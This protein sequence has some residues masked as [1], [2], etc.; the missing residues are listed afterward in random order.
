M[1]F[2]KN[3]QDFILVGIQNDFL[4]ENPSINKESFFNG[5]E[6]NKEAFL[7]SKN[8][9]LNPTL[10]NAISDLLQSNGVVE[11]ETP[12]F[13]EGV[14]GEPISNYQ[15]FVRKYK[16]KNAKVDSHRFAKHTETIRV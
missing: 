2:L 3:E 4:N 5:I 6:N 14:Y 11:S 12:K 9:T 16:R 1:V 8:L 10:E 7:V 15:K 13:K